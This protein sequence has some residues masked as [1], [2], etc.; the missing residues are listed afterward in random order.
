MSVYAQERADALADIREAGAVVVF[1]RT[2][3]GTY[4]PATGAYGGTVTTSTGYAIA[5]R[6]TGGELERLKTLGVDVINTK[7]QSLL[8]AAE[9]MAFAPRPD[10]R[11][12]WGGATYTVRDVATLDLNAA[13]PILYFVAVTR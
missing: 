6:P 1:T 9:G 10:D 4:D 8:C 7:G 13:E 3:P 2:Q 12:L 5:R 11:C